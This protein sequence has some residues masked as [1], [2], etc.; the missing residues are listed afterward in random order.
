MSLN[1][2][3]QKTDMKNDILAME[4]KNEFPQFSNF[5]NRR[6][7][8]L[9][10]LN[11][12]PKPNFYSNLGFSNFQPN[13]NNPKDQPHPPNPGRPKK[14]NNKSLKEPEF[15]S[16]KESEFK[17]YKE[18]EFKP[19]KENP[20]EKT[21]LLEENNS[22]PM[23]ELDSLK[24]LFPL[25][26]NSSFWEL[27]D[28]ITQNKDLSKE[29]SFKK[30]EDNHEK[31]DNICKEISML[32]KEILLKIN[33]CN[34]CKNFENEMLAFQKKFESL[35]QMLLNSHAKTDN[36][37]EIFKKIEDFFNEN[38]KITGYEL[39]KNRF[40]ENFLEFVFEGALSTIYEIT[41]GPKNSENIDAFINTDNFEMKC[42]ESEHD[43]NNEISQTVQTS[44]LKRII[45]FY[46]YF[47]KHS[48]NESKGNMIFI[49]NAN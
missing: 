30:D 8:Y 11:E 10:N 38:S 47:S 13:L 18:P 21:S 34:L 4:N 16:F 17:S 22:M 25:K 24:P 12:E 2:I 29:D 6:M 9:F 45:A 7:N 15:K 28:K 49:K 32:A 36:N 14:R 44:I 23:N 37:L 39:C 43:L 40:C 48:L 20:E 27:N 35:N 5:L 46:F 41:Q 42:I 19:L 26:N 31:T 1:N 33:K 3:L